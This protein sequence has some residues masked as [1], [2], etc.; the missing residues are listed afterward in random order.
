MRRLAASVS[1]NVNESSPFTES[2]FDYAIAGREECVVF[3]D[4]DV[5]SRMKFCSAL[6]NDYAP[7]VNSLTGEYFDAESLGI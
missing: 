6:T 2:E 5:A 1:Y 7:G 4:S 3:S